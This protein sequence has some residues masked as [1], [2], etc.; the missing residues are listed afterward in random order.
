MTEEL[1]KQMAEAHADKLCKREC[2]V[3]WKRLVATYIAG[4][5][6]IKIESD[7]LDAERQRLTKENTGL[8]VE[9]M[10]LMHIGSILKDCASWWKFR[11]HKDE[12]KRLTNAMEIAHKEWKGVS[13]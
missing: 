6:S 5:N 2:A 9:N 11:K 12:I 10:Y 13:L 7:M 4:T 8:M 3:E 1:I